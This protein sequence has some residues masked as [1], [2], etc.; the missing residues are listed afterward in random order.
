[1]LIAKDDF[2]FLAGIAEMCLVTHRIV[3]ISTAY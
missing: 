2:G 3:R 1:M